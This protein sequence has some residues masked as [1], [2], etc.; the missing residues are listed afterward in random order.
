[1]GGFTQNSI[2]DNVGRPSQGA[3]GAYLQPVQTSQDGGSERSGGLWDIIR[4]M[5]AMTNYSNYDAPDP[6]KP[7]G[8]PI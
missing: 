2:W 8:R 6:M 3:C 1:M 7:E 4:Q 5:P